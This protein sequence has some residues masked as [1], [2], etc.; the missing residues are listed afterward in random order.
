M[1]WGKWEVR[2]RGRAGL[3][4]QAFVNCTEGRMNEKGLGQGLS[5][6]SLSNERI[7]IAKSKQQ[8]YQR[9][10]DDI[11]LLRSAPTNKRH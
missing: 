8:C 6:L 1:W 7:G 2:L 11:F 9:Q 3:S 5:D 4:H 10:P